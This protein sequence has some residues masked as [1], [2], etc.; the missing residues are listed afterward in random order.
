MALDDSS[1]ARTLLISNEASSL[2]ASQSRTVFTMYVANSS[3]S[4]RV[5]MVGITSSS[6]SSHPS[7]QLSRLNT[8]ATVMAAGG[9][10][11]QTPAVTRLRASTVNA[12][13]PT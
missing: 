4:P 1:S 11:S 2:S 13:N 12:N 3:N 6:R 7:D 10:F 5:R 8:T 9:F